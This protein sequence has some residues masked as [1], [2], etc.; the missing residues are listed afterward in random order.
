YVF[1]AT[2]F[3]L[4]VS[5]FVSTQVAAIFATAIL[6]AMTAAHYSGFLFP[7]S[8]L[9]G[10]ARVMGLSFPALWFQ[11]VSLGVF[12][13]GLGANAFITEIA[14]LIGFGIVFLLLARL[15]VRKQ[16]I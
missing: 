10:P 8:T 4:L 15:S 13:K 5:A 16:S 7:A 6:T 9:E 1:A 12:A 14:V 11:T 2:A 3:G